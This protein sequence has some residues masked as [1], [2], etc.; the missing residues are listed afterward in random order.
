MFHSGSGLRCSQA[1]GSMS[2]S[3]SGGHWHSGNMTNLC[4]LSSAMQHASHDTTGVALAG[5]GNQRQGHPLRCRLIVDELHT[6][7]TVFPP[8]HYLDHFKALCLG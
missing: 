7:K 3:R 6:W 2:V 5:E 1:T 4:S 8:M